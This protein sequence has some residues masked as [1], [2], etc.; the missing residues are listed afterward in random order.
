MN[1]KPL[2][3]LL[4][5]VLASCG[6]TKKITTIEDASAKEVISAHKAVAPDFKTLAGRVQLVYETDE[7]LQSIIVG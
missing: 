2:Y 7:K 6:G 1:L 3:I 5:L 4:L